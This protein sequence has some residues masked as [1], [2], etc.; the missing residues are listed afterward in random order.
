MMYMT[1]AG[2]AIAQAYGIHLDFGTQ[3]PMLLVLMLISKG[4]AGVPRASL[5]VVTATSSMVGIPPEG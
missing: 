4:I 2:L 3:L 5:V 1:V